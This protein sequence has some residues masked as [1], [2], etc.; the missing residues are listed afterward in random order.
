MKS[1]RLF[2][3][4]H[5]AILVWAFL[6]SC[7]NQLAGGD[8][9][10]TGNARV[11]GKVVDTLGFGKKNVHVQLLPSY[12]DPVRGGIPLDSLST[13][14][15][16]NGNYTI[17]TSIIGNYNIEVINPI[18]GDRAL[19]HNIDI[20]LNDT[21]H[22]ENAILQ[23][24]GAIKIVLSSDSGSDA[25]YAYIPG[26][27]RFGTTNGRIV[28]ID[29]VPAGS[30]KALCY[31]NQLDTTENRSFNKEFSVISGC[32][33]IMTDSLSWLFS[34]KLYFNTTLSGA[35]VN[36][37][38]YSFPVL[39]RLSADNFDFSQAKKDGEDIRFGKAD[40]T[41]L[42]CEIERWEPSNSRAEIWVK[43]DTIYGNTDN[44]YIVMYWGNTLAQDV[45]SSAAV[46]DTSSGFQGVWHLYE[47]GDITNDATGNVFNGI[48]YGATPVEGII[49]NAK[50]F[51]NG[52][53]I[54]IPGLLNSPSS[55]TLS[56]WVSAGPT[57]SAQ[58]GNLSQEIVSIGDAVLIRL[59]NATGIGTCGSYHNSVNTVGK[60]NSF[61]ITGSGRNLANTGWHY[62]VFS[63]NSA[64]HVQT[65]YINGEQCAVSNDVNPI[66][67]DGLGNN[68]FIGIHGNGL[69]TSNFNGLIDEVRVNKTT[70]SSDWVKLCYMNQKEQDALIK[71]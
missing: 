2:I 14:T 20:K 34:R 28:I 65:F 52:S 44:Q 67:Y 7:S 4:A 3:L 51:S 36:E 41:P 12:F 22:N 25:V 50:Y 57:D 27:T 59:D 53:N 15:D 55:I 11:F 42:P 6:F 62:I 54:Q 48:N 40:G 63:I 23:K 66:T 60:D 26:T 68:T 37:N 35:A 24:T 58:N 39:I 16:E 64:T 1:D 33:A 49:G 10:E 9:T 18:S 21:I 5:A 13:T 31:V 17:T 8:V 61:V 45:S 19:I 69:K 29:S 46:F 71:W 32:T 56:A 43:M 47:N 30:Y 70:L 38:V